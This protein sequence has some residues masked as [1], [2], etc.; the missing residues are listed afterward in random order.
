MFEPAPPSHPGIPLKRLASQ[1]EPI[2]FFDEVTL[3]EDE[4]HDCGMANLVVKVVR[5]G[6]AFIEASE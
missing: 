3:F 4:L 1:D 5:A 6:L 2:L